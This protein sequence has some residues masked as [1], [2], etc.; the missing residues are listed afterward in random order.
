[1]K[2]GKI[3]IIQPPFS[4]L[5]HRFEETMKFAEENGIDVMCYGSLGGGILTGKYRE[6]PNWPSDDVRLT[7]YKGFKE[8]TFS[9]TMELLKTIDAISEKYNALPLQVVLNWTT[10]KRYVSTALIGVTTL[11]H[12]Q[13]NVDA[14]NFQLT[15]EE[16]NQ[17]DQEIQR[18]ELDK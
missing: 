12:V 5:D 7:F 10:Q 18:L 11:K 8:P 13:E 2:Y 16:M 14:L 1:M 4:M 15:D 9:K 3:D 6:I 17:I